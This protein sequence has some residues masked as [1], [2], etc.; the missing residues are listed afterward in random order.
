MEELVPKTCFFITASM[1]S[2]LT[3]GTQSVHWTMMPKP[4]RM[5]VWSRVDQ[6]LPSRAVR[7][8]SSCLPFLPTNSYPILTSS[9]TF[10]QLRW[11][12]GAAFALLLNATATAQITSDW[13]ISPANP[14]AT[15]P[16]TPASYGGGLLAYSVNGE[17]DLVRPI[18]NPVGFVAQPYHSGPVARRPVIAAVADLPGG[19]PRYYI[20]ATMA[21]GYLIKLDIGASLNMPDLP[22]QVATSA[23]LVPQIRRIRRAG[24]ASDTLIAEPV[25][26]RRVDSNAQFMPDVDLVIVATAHRCGDS[27][28]NQIIALNAA[29]VTAPPIWVFNAGEYE[30]GT[31]H[32][33][34]LDLPRN[35]LHC[36][37][38]EPPSSLQ[39]TIWTLD[40]ST[41]SLVWAADYGGASMQSLPALA[42]PSASTDGHLYVGDMGGTV[43][44]LDVASGNQIASATVSGVGAKGISYDLSVADGLGAGLVFA[45]AENGTLSAFRDTG[46]DLILDWNPNFAGGQH[47]VSSAA[48]VSSLNK[49]YVGVSDGL[50][51]QFDMAG[52]EEALGDIGGNTGLDSTAVVTTYLPGDGVFRLVGSNFKENS[53]TGVVVRQY[54]MPCD[55]SHPNY[56]LPAAGHVRPGPRLLLV[57]D[58]DNTPDGLAAYVRTLD[59]LGHRYDVWDTHASDN[60]PGSA[61]L[62]RYSAVAWWSGHASMY[63]GPGPATLSNGLGPWLNQGGCWLLS[64]PYFAS[65]SMFGMQDFGSYVH[66]GVGGDIEPTQVTGAGATFGGLGP[67]LLAAP[68]GN[69]GETWIP[70]ADASSAFTSPQGSLGTQ[71]DSGTFRSIVVGFPL[72]ALPE[73]GRAE[74]LSLFQDYCAM[75]RVPADRVFQDGFEAVV[76]P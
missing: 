41:G 35:L 25:V 52:F 57:D 59:A 24:C 74:V 10:P 47:V 20:F 14:G 9:R 34:L 4:L 5:C 51:H 66:A 6:P 15:S 22:L 72:E 33:C 21:D 65:R 1:A 28:G 75:P 48:V 18:G 46:D 44:V 32:A 3:F 56:C 40:T 60:E 31:I 73:L 61:L 13:S 17:I 53:S 55:S 67:Y 37:S 49:V 30:V 62:G 71:Y 43:H 16:P 11:L 64:S 38:E 29:D 70:D 42:P 54:Q 39:N 63:A 50:F 76:N 7:L 68:Y 23:S 12:V 58:D 27:T 8:P 45:V 26:Q 69:H 19:N 2:M 36:V